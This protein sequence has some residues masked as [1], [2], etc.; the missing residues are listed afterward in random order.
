MSDSKIYYLF[1]LILF[2][3]C[4]LVHYSRTIFPIM[5]YDE[6]FVDKYGTIHNK[7]CSYKSVPWFTKKESKYDFIKKKGQ[8]YCQECISSF[9]EEKMEDLHQL[10]V[11][12]RI[13]YL[14]SRGATQEYID[15]ELERYADD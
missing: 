13:L 3:V 12:H 7:D 11:E 6:Y 4:A 10:N 15:K 2:G 9:D 14:R 8:K 1:L 5:D